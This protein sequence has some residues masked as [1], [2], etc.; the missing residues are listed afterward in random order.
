[1]LKANAKR[2]DASVDVNF[3]PN[4]ICRNSV[5]PNRVCLLFTAKMERKFIVRPF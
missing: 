3:S 1:L 5:C 2:N 4:S